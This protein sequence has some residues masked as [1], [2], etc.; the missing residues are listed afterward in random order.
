MRHIE[1][2]RALLVQ[3]AMTPER[4]ADALVLIGEMD[5]EVEP[6]KARWTA[7]ELCQ[8]YSG[9]PRA[10]RWKDGRIN[11]ATAEK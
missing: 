9:D 7:G 2:E 1:V 8:L 4:F 10:I 11:C 6:D 3:R 5:G